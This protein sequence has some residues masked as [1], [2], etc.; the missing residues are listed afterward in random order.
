[1]LV[2]IIVIVINSANSDE[3][4]KPYGMIEGHLITH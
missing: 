2:V 4:G 1:M 3:N